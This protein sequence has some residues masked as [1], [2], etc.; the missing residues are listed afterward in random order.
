MRKIYTL[1]ALFTVGVMS[2]GSAETT[3]KPLNNK[4]KKAFSGKVG[5]LK[6]RQLAKSNSSATSRWY[7][8][9]EAV[10]KYTMANSGDSSALGS[11]LMFPDSTLKYAFSDGL[12]NAFHALGQVL[13]AADTTFNTQDYSGEM[14]LLPTSTYTVD[15]VVTEFF[16]RRNVNTQNNAQVVDSLII[17]LGSNTANSQLPT[18]G[19]ASN[20]F[21]T[22]NFGVDAPSFKDL[23]YKYQT[24]GLGTFGNYKR[25]AI[26]LD[27][28]FYA[29]TTD[30]GSNIVVLPTSNLGQVS[31][32]RLVVMS[33]A[34]K[35]G[36]TWTPNV[37]TLNNFNYITFL[38]YTEMTNDHANTIRYFQ[39]TNFNMAYVALT[40]MRYNISTN[41]NGSMYPR[42]GFSKTYDIDQYYFMYKISSNNAGIV[43]VGLNDVSAN[44]ATTV[45]PN[46]ATDMINVTLNN[47][48]SLKLVDI[49]GR[50]VYSENVNNKNN[51]TINMSNLAKGIYS[52]QVITST[53][54][55][56]KKVVKQ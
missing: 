8:Y 22:D 5:Q 3:I 56:T 1:I 23:S 54:V 25:Y 11:Y 26:A 50:V 21:F 44:S 52:L 17:E 24:N 51:T 35:P 13:H 38:H 4:D 16:Y 27:S 14:K 12:G 48:N 55:E 41:W 40:D 37:D 7:D 36:F 46:P 53:G 30:Y 15:T 9:G 2:H 34:F 20:T 18:V 19:F 42:L 49:N 28:A 39:S 32:G 29:D 33:M 6:S 47:V 45:S 31:A 10:S 43:T